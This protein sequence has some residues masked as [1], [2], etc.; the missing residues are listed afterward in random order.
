MWCNGKEVFR[1]ESGA[2]IPRFELKVPLKAGDNV[3][4][5]KV[6]AGSGGHKIIALLAAE[7]GDGADEEHDG[8]LDS[9]TLYDDD[10]M[11]FDPYEFHY[12]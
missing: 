9:M 8:E 1:T 3:L 2:R 5:F 10:V 12:W 6:G 4:A 11:G 7:R